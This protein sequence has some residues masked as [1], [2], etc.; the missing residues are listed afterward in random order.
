MTE[1]TQEGDQPESYIYDTNEIAAMVKSYF[2]EDW[3]DGK[4]LVLLRSETDEIAHF[5][6][7]FDP[8]DPEEYPEGMSMPIAE[9]MVDMMTGE[10]FVDYESRTFLW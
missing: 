6:L 3:K 4:L 2:A 9:I 1:A 5:S 8:D 7:K 10:M